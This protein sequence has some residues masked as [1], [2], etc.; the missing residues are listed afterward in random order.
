M[1]YARS[2]PF[3]PNQLLSIPALLRTLLHTFFAQAAIFLL[4]DHPDKCYDV[5]TYPL[6]LYVTQPFRRVSV[7]SWAVQLLH[8]PNTYQRWSYEQVENRYSLF[9]PEPRP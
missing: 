7:D 4:E 8:E 1:G 2:L 9:R 6:V 5:D 3:A